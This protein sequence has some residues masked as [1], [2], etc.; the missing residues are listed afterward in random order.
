M[1][2][3]FPPFMG[4]NREDLKKNIDKGK[5]LYP[6]DVAGKISKICKHLISQLLM[7][8]V[9]ERMTWK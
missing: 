7:S 2:C 1:V 4:K 3:G 8:N 6:P 5:Y 9:E